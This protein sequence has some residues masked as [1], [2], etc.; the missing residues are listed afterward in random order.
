VAVIITLDDLPSSVRSNELAELMVDGANA[1][2]SRVAPCLAAT[3]SPWAASAAYVIGD[4]VALAGGELLQVVTAGTSDATEPT[5][6]TAVGRTVTDG[7]VTWQR[8][9]PAADQ[10]HEAR[11]ILVGAV[12]RWTEASSGAMQ[13]QTAGPFSMVTDTRQRTGFNLWPSEIEALQSLCSTATKSG[14]FSLNTAPP[15]TGLHLD[16]CS[17]N[18]GA[19][20]CSCGADIA[21]YPIFEGSD[22]Y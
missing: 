21:G 17:I 2:A 8:V 6:P 16:V 5:A 10:L 20:Y 18:F 9:E 7:T 11:L 1:K 13:S 3:T 12:K 22:T 15:L 4:R 14:A 19:T